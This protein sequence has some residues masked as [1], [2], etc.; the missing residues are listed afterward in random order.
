MFQKTI[1]LLFQILYTK[2]FEI[3]LEELRDLGYR[4]PARIMV[5]FEVAIINA[6]MEMFG[7]V[8]ACFFHLCQNIYRKVV[9]VGL[10]VQYAD[11][12][13]TTVRDATRKIC[14]LAFV[15]VADV[16]RVFN[17]LKTSITRSTPQQFSGVITY[18]CVSNNLNI[19]EFVKNIFFHLY[20]FL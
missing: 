19:P 13:D 8:L 3:V 15:P 6:A 4:L 10:K 16:I 20:A 7:N 5:G 12:N 18:F 1:Y 14:A 17:L 11:E 9:D 2:M